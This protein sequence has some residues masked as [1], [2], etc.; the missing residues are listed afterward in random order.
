MYKPGSD[1]LCLFPVSKFSSQFFRA[2]LW[3]EL[4]KLCTKD[5]GFLKVFGPLKKM[6]SFEIDYNFFIFYHNF[7]PNTE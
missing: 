1:R 3:K 2:I 7:I 4:E 5:T 6:M